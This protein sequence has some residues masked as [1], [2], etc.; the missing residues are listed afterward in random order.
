M[1]LG[2]KILLVAVAFFALASEVASSA[3][4]DHDHHSD[5]RFVEIDVGQSEPASSAH[6]AHMCVACHNLMDPRAGFEASIEV[7][8][9][10]SFVF[11]DVRFRTR[12]LEPPFQPPIEISA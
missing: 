4:P 2:V 11:P 10:P 5:E 8:S 1:N 12:A 7:S 9:T 3:A 6:A